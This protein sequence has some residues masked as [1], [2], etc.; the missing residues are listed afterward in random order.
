MHCS[1]I[2]CIYICTFI[3]AQV[4][5]PLLSPQALQ[6]QLPPWLNKDV[7]CKSATRH[8][9]PAQTSYA[10]TKARLA[11]D[12]SVWSG[13]TLFRAAAHLKKLAHRRYC[14]RLFW[15]LMLTDVPKWACRFLSLSR[16]LLWLLTDLQMLI[17]PALLSAWYWARGADRLHAHF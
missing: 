11:H 6:Y 4:T 15:F 10:S 9:M 1:L 7:N 8:F 16:L 3:S 2:F 14:L 12:H 5:K 13:C 17:G